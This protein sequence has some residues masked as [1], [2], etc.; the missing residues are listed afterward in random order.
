MAETTKAQTEHPEGGHGGGTFPPF[1]SSTFA[2]QIVWLAIAFGLLY[3]LMSRVALPRVATILETRR[4]RIAGDLKAAQQLKAD[5]DRAVEAYETSLAQARAKAQAIAAETRDAVNA[6]TETKRKTIEASLGVKL[7]A[8][9]KQ[10]A[11]TRDA[12]L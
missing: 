6:E 3:L 9:E 5:S 10:I 4:E 1:E 11:A 8:A 12:A 7:A 2:T